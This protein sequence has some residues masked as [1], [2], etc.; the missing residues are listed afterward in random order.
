MHIIYF[1]TCYYWNMVES[2]K[3]SHIIS[4]I[5][6]TARKICLLI[7]I[8]DVTCTFV[9]CLSLST[10]QSSVVLLIG[11]VLLYNAGKA[12]GVGGRAGKVLSLGDRRRPATHRQTTHL[13]HSDHTNTCVSLKLNLF[14]QHDQNCHFFHFLCLL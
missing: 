1:E 9:M 7:W 11:L 8:K 12:A 14:G 2:I 6:V 13:G 10:Y 4:A 5:Q 3:P